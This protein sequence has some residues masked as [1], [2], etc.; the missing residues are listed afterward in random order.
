VNHENARSRAVPVQVEGARRGGRAD[1]LDQEFS[2]RAR[3]VLAIGPGRDDPTGHRQH[4]LILVPVRG[5]SAGHLERQISDGLGR[6]AAHAELAG[7]AVEVKESVHSLEKLEV[8]GLVL[9]VHQRPDRPVRAGPR[10]EGHH[11][12]MHV[13]RERGD[14]AVGAAERGD[15]VVRV[16][17]GAELGEA[18]GGGIEARDRA[19][20]ISADPDGPVR[21]LVQPGGKGGVAGVDGPEILEPPP[22]TSRVVTQQVA[23]AGRADVEGPGVG[24]AK[25]IGGRLRGRR[26]RV[27][28]DAV[29]GGEVDI[30][31]EEAAIVLA[32]RGQQ[33]GPADRPA[34]VSVMQDL[35]ARD[36]QR[37]LGIGCPT[38]VQPHP[39]D[40]FNRDAEIPHDRLRGR[41]QRQG[42]E[43]K[44]RRDEFQG[45]SLTAG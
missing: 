26:R 3:A 25:G 39:A 40:R 13:D 5:I 29:A 14:G 7:V 28:L 11:V 32:H 19:F 21:R 37:G 42:Q 18:A 30:E 34:S 45:R 12:G 33:G 44:R 35:L 6:G 8:L 23:V 22:G 10:I 4:L 2:E 16:V 38:G 27:E 36:Q 9:V 24:T 41:K 1:V 31:D 15:I 43:K 17:E 20:R